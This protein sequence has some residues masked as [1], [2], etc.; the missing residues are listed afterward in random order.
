MKTVHNRKNTESEERGKI[1]DSEG[2]RKV[3]G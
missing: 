2:E 1:A 3:I